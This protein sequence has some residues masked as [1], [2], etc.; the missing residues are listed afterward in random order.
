MAGDRRARWDGDVA[1]VERVAVIHH[2]LVAQHREIL[3]LDPPALAESEVEQQR[4]EDRTVLEGEI[5]LE[6]QL[7][8]DPLGAVD[9][10]DGADRWC[11][12][13][14]I[15]EE[16]RIHLRMERIRQDRRRCR[17]PERKAGPQQGMSCGHGVPYRKRVVVQLAGSRAVPW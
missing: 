11:V 15:K 4:G 9:P 17:Q 1:D 2:L 7:G 5:V 13:P 12:G 16:L 14:G 6:A 3:G 8:A 10:Q